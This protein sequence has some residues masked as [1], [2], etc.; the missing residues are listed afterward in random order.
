MTLDRDTVLAALRPEDVASHL[1]ITGG[2]RG[3]WLRSRRCGKADHG[4][5]AF[6]LSRQGFWH[7]HACDQ[8]G[9]L[10]SLL[11]VSEGL[12]V[13]ADFPKVIALAAQIAGVEDDGDE[14]GANQR[15]APK[16]RAPL[17]PL[18][19][20][21]ERVALA[22]R[23]AAWVW[24]RLV[25]REE[26]R[27]SASDGYLAQ[28][29][30]DAARVRQ[31]EDLRETPMRCTLEEVARAADLKSLAYN[32]AVPGLAVPVRGVD[33]DGSMVDVR[34]RRFEPRTGQ[35]KIMTMTGAVTVGPAEAG[36]PRSLVGCFG[37]PASVDCD[38]VVIVEG[39]MD[40]LTALQFW[41]GAQVLGAVD[42][43]QL[44]LV[45]A[46]AAQQLAWRDKE[47]RILIV[48]QNDGVGGAADRSVNEDP[49]AATKVAVRALGPR[50]VGWLFCDGAGVKDLNDLV[51][52]GAPVS[53]MIRWWVDGP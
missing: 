1:G 49:N 14:W 48:E 39:L 26:L 32:F 36:R 18:P 16:P 9:D 41:P 27:F 3:R 53:E 25:R 4:S 20:L 38:L 19:P 15:P 28:R 46:H 47:S 30:L 44:A 50:R 23:R 35:P 52:T 21:V 33:A 22:K 51:R 12:D 8:G 40:Y 43:G 42:A 5:E 45:T 10:L 29:G 17:P 31:R 24:S 6:G 7:C 34:V 37:R 11:A 2:W 13:R